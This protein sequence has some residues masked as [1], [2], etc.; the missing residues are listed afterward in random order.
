MDQPK[1][2]G[3]IARVQ[4]RVGDAKTGPLVAIALGWLLVLGARFLVPAVL[5]QVKASFKFDNA[6]AGFAVTLVWMGYALMQFPAGVLVDRLGERMLL[7]GS[8]GLAGGSLV[9]MGTAPTPPVFLAACGMLGLS[10][11]LYGPARGT[12]LS[13]IFTEGSGLA[14]GITLAAGSLGSA[15]LP[16]LTSLLLAMHGWRTLMTG[17]L[18]PFIAATVLTWWQVPPFGRDS[19][20]RDRSVRDTATDVVGAIT[21]PTLVRVVM[22]MTLMLFIFQGLTAFLPT[23]L[24]EEKGLGQQTAVGLFALLFLSGALSQVTAGRATDLFGVRRILLVVATLGAL[25]L[26]ALPLVEGVLPLA[27]LV[28]LLGSRLAASPVTNNFVVGT[29]PDQVTGVSWGLLRTLF[30]ILGS[31]GSWFVGTL[32]D[33]GYFDSAFVVLAVLS[34]CAAILYVSLPEETGA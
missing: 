9:A 15:V 28:L 23:Y 13:K 10:S 17:L 4:R 11:G 31:T 26:L 3:L 14:F 32:A 29:L 19:G 5:P 25:T 18:G 34:A 30:F 22:A 12:V 6:S 24:I 1:V 7:A 8:L 33:A 21:D 16:Y 27:I 2:S 20:Q